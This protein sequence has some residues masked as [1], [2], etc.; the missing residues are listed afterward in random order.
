MPTLVE[1]DLE[2]R[3]GVTRVT[4][5]HSKF[6]DQKKTAD[7]V[8]T[9]WMGILN[10]IKAVVETGT[11]PFKTRLMLRMMSAFMFLLPKGT[12]RENIPEL[13]EKR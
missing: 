12:L 9:S 1:W 5:T 13:K 3:S 10:N 7:S 4:V 11:V 2:E 6:V 8:R